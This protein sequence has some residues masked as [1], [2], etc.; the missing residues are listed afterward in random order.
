[1]KSL[2]PGELVVHLAG[3]LIWVVSLLLAAGLSVLLFLL[4]LMRGQLG[5]EEV[6]NKEME[7]L[8]SKKKSMYCRKPI[9]LT[10]LFCKIESFFQRVY[11]SLN[12]L[13][14]YNDFRQ[15]ESL[16]ILDKAQNQYSTFVF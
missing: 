3:V 10:C 7:V 16:Y 9:L 8:R 14:C 15:N 13:Q 11:N 2:A 1:M 6:T 12:F 5:K 4:R